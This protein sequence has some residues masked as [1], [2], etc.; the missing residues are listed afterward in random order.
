MAAQ[1]NMKSVKNPYLQQQIKTASPEKLILML[2]DIGLKS[3]KAKDRQKAA[4]VLVELIGS[5]NFDYKEIALGYFELYRFA[6]DGIHRGKFENAIWVLQ[7]L[8]DVW[9]S[10]VMG[11]PAVSLN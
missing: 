10:A 3:C 5:L 4:K 1:M 11:Q 2:Y 7:G 8:R 6:L 9:K